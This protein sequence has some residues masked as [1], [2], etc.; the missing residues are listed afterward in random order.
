MNRPAAPR[1]RLAILAATL[2]AALGLAA[3][4]AAATP[5]GLSGRTFLS[6]GVT[7][8]GADQPLF[9]DSRV[10]LV[11]GADGQ[12]GASAGCNSIGGTWAT[13]GT[14]LSMQAGAMTE[15]GCDQQLHAQ[16]DWLVEFLA[17]GP[18][19]ALAGSDLTLTVGDTVMV[20]ADREV[21]EPDLA[22]IGQT[23]L[24][25]TLISGDAA[26]SLPA[27]VVAGLEFADDGTVQVRTGC[28]EGSATWSIDGDAIRFGPIATTKRGCEPGPAE[29]ERIVLGVLSSPQLTVA[30]DASTLT[31]S[32]PTGGL[33]LSPP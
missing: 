12:L 13:D 32:G 3:C 27:G 1:R 28:N 26:S 16:D 8:G 4:G 14:R 17:A 7:V 15:M 2:V 22:L 18:T 30:I 19:I 5:P 23:W 20:L 9:G 21:A 29:T 31:L 11:F 24:V 10:R 6:T 25:T 33:Q